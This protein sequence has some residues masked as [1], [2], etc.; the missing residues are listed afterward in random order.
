MRD[1]DE[2]VVYRGDKDDPAVQEALRMV[3]ELI[4][5][6]VYFKALVP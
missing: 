3:D 4:D 5:N 1:A 2:V 6:Y